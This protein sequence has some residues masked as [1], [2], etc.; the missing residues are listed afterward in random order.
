MS[1]S[2]R[3]TTAGHLP[4]PGNAP[5]FR[6]VVRAWWPL[7][8]S[9]LLMAMELPAVGAIMAR[10]PDPKISLAAYGG[11]V[12]PLSM[13]IEAP[14]IML[15]SASTALSR[16]LASYLLLR[17]FM[18][19]A[20][21]VLTAL[22]AAIAFT[23]LFDVVVGGIINPPEPVLGPAR[24]GLMIMTFWTWSIAYRRFHQGVLIRFGRSHLVGIGTLVRLGTNILVLAFGFLHGRIPGIIV[25]A[26]AVGLGVLAEAVFI[27]IVARPTL[28]GDLRAAPRIEPP[29]DWRAFFSFYIPLALTSL[30]MLLTGPMISAAVSRMPRALDSLAVWPVL[31]GMTFLLRSLG[32]AFNE[33]VVAMLDRP[34][35][36]PMLRRFAGALALSTSALLLLVALTPLA[37]I[38]L[39][40][41][42]GLSDDLTSLAAGAVILVA[43]M[44]G[45]GAL[46]SW[47]QGTIVHSRRTRGVTESVLIGLLANSAMLLAGLMHGAVPGLYAGLA[48]MVTGTAAQTVWL[49]WRSRGLRR[50]LATT[51]TL[52]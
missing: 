5:A 30:L 42:S 27:G 3:E 17:R 12:F 10:L 8:G 31:N 7:A 38:Y 52:S 40:D 25:G 44:P 35:A 18:L 32:L 43:V 9:W 51:Q 46:Q 4:G 41:I 16:D 20:G 39:H 19:R 26:S 21:F 14:I 49:W 50:G 34:R 33:V 37:R 1:R 48:A 24:T 36:A 15:L 28:R 45:L 13:I 2:T 29:L 47:Y 23:P 22:H 6:D 11:V